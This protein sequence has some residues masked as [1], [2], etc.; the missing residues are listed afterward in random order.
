[1]A[2]CCSCLENMLVLVNC[3]KWRGLNLSNPIRELTKSIHHGMVATLHTQQQTTV[4]VLD[5]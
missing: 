2:C 4:T 1:M 5:A 3:C